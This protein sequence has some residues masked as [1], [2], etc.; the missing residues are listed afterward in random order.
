MGAIILTEVIDNKT[1]FEL[2]NFFVICVWDAD[3]ASESF[4]PWNVRH[5]RKK[6]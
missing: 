6:K 2:D 3:G 5:L 4:L 1:I